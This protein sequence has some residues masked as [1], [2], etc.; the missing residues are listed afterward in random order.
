MT[1]TM[2][3]REGKINPEPVIQWDIDYTCHERN[4]KCNTDQGQIE[5]GNYMEGEKIIEIMKKRN[6]SFYDT[7][8]DDNGNVVAYQFV[9]EPEYR[10]GK[11]DVP[12]YN[13]TVYP[14]SGEYQFAFAVPNTENK[15]KLETVRCDGFENDDIF[16]SI[17]GNFAIG[18]MA[19]NIEFGSR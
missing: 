1:F 7:E 14:E 2:N 13:C 17:C 9:T 8:T 19:L 4:D 5:R 12:S 18:I 15:M 10:N 3:S 11:L 16:D 6:F